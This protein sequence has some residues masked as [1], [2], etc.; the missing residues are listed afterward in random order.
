M[1]FILSLTLNV[2]HFKCKPIE[3]SD[4]SQAPGGGGTPI[5][6]GG[7]CA[8]G[9]AKVLP[10]TRPNFANFVTLYQTKIAQLFLNSIFC[11]RSR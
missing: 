3:Y 11:E 6:F 10:F 7:G 1:Q 9:F 2:L 5:Q 8:V 4:D